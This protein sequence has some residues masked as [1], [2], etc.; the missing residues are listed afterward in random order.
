M[1]KETTRQE[2]PD[3]KKR[4]FGMFPLE[5]DEDKQLDN[6]V[7]IPDIIHLIPVGNWKHDLYGDM[8]INYADIREFQANFNAGIRKGVFITAGHEGFEELPA[9]A[10]IT[11]VEARDDGLWGMVDWNNEGRELLSDKA[12]KFFSPEFYRDYEDPQTHEQY[13]NVLTGGA[14]T[15]SPYFK[16]LAPV[17]FSDKILKEKFNETNNMNLTEILTK[18]IE[19]LTAEETAFIK[20][21]AAQLTDEQKAT[22]TSIIDAPAPEPTPEPAKT[23]E[24]KVE[25]PKVEEPK[26]EEPKPAEEP[27]TDEPKTE[28]PATP[29][30]PEPEVEKVQ[31]SEKVMITASE[32]KT[33]REEN[34]RAK[35]MFKE[36]EAK[37]VTETIKKLTFSSNNKDGKFL[38]KSAD[39]L[40]AFM[41]KLP[42]DMRAQFSAL[43][44]ELPKSLAFNE[45][46][47]GVGAVEGTAE[48]EVQSKVNAKLSEKS[49]M[50]YA[51]ALK[52]VFAENADLQKR[53]TAELKN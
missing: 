51:E 20:E 3:S 22:Y 35:A 5:F 15:K 45:I 23:E 34:D 6:G 8:S 11:E 21:N 32:L 39:N 31:A 14:L 40:K 53:Y 28:E 7:K 30:A 19:D 44:A 33:M 18:K 10:W 46:G 25:E 43:L 17:I 27:K 37:E 2:K 26:T 1:T 12:F 38:P 49:G 13:K 16:E 48:A 29:A 52:E 41:E 4:I 42:K 9:V 24:P 50:K 47:S 36:I